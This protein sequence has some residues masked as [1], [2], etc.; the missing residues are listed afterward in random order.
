VG[1]VITA[2]KAPPLPTTNAT[3]TVD[4]R[5]IAVRIFSPF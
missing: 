4:V 3:I 5:R 2:A 1:Q